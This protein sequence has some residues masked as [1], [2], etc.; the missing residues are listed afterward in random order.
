MVRF[1]MCQYV[2]TLGLCGEDSRVVRC[3]FLW[4]F[5]RTRCCRQLWASK[6]YAGRVPSLD[7]SSIQA[8]IRAVSNN[9]PGSPAA[10][11]DFQ[12]SQGAAQPLWGARKSLR[13]LIYKDPPHR[14]RAS[15]GCGSVTPSAAPA[16]MSHHAIS[17]RSHPSGDVNYRKV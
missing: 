1:V 5:S 8:R 2:S 6:D 11:D 4:L 3:P 14:A 10:A 13:I 17:L 9:H 15:C 16:S 12:L 7:D